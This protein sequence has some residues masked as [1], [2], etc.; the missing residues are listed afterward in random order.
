[1]EIYQLSIYIAI[2]IPV[3]SYDIDS[4]SFRIRNGSTTIAYYSCD[5]RDENEENFHC[6]QNF[7]VYRKAAKISVAGIR[8]YVTDEPQFACG[9]VDP[10][11][12]VSIGWAALVKLSDNDT[13]D[14]SVEQKLLQVQQAGYQMALLM[15]TNCSDENHKV[16]FHSDTNASTINISAVTVYKKLADQLIKY[17]VPT[18]N[19]DGAVQAI[20]R[21]HYV[22]E[23]TVE[24]VLI[25]ISLFI[26]VAVVVCSPFILVFSYLCCKKLLRCLRQDEYEALTESNPLP[27][28]GNQDDEFPK[29]Q[30]KLKDVPILAT[31]NT[32]KYGGAVQE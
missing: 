19:N 22:K 2:V 16:N 27:N 1:M 31:K 26:G 25:G 8:G 4:R 32:Y 11:N 21:V 14:C 7:I 15:Y 13:C 6:D 18:A 3:L 24:D 28:D 12:N 17:A 29:S 23:V 10:P 5:H 30:E 9:E 20:V